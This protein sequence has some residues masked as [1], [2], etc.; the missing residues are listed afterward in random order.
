[1]IFICFKNGDWRLTKIVTL[2]GMK[3]NGVVLYIKWYAILNKID[4]NDYPNDKNNFYNSLLT[5]M[6]IIN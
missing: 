3:D 2:L 6:N 4:K 1:L 5:L